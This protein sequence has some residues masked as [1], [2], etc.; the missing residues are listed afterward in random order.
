MIPLELQDELVSRMQEQFKHLRLKNLLNKQVPINIFSQHLPTRSKIDESNNLYPCIIVRLA[1]GSG[2]QGNTEN[3][4]NVQ[5]I[6]G[7]IDRESSNQ[8][9]RDALTVGNKIIENL[10][11]NPVINSKFELAEK[12]NWA[13]HD[14]D[15]EPYYFA[16]IETTWRTPSFL[17]EDVEDLI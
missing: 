13:Y 15:S 4:T 1:N 16:G 8:G 12:I 6:I 7:V 14:E 17:R 9:Y 5:F 10:K 11:R 3:S 2:Y